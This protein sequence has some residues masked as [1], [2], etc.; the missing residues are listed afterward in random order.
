[1]AILPGSG[2]ET[3]AEL[4]PCGGGGVGYE[5]VAEEVEAVGKL[6]V[7]SLHPT[8]SPIKHS[9][10]SGFRSTTLSPLGPAHVVVGLWW[11]TAVLCGFVLSNPWPFMSCAVG[12]GHVLARWTRL[13]PPFLGGSVPLN[14]ADPTGVGHILASTVRDVTVLRPNPAFIA[15]CASGE[16]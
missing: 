7:A 16:R 1:M 12:V 14:P 4:P 2:A 8:G 11:K 15:R 13:D 6:R 10:N 9:T 3:G 5:P